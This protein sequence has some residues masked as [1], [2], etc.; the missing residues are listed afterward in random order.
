MR[1]LLLV[2]LS[3]PFA[4]RALAA[5][6]PAEQPVLLA[7]VVVSGL[8]PGPGMWRVHHGEH[9]L[10]VLATVR[11]LPRDIEWDAHEVEAVIAQAQEVLGAPTVKLRSDRGRLRSMLLLPA[12]LR[13]RRDPDGRSLEAQ[14]PP[15]DY[16]RWTVLKARYIGRDRAVE[17]RRPLLAAQALYEAAIEDVGLSQRSVVRPVVRRAARRHDVPRTEVAVELEIAN[18]KEAVRGLAAARLDDLD[19]FRST[20]ARIET[21]L[22]AMRR[23]ANAWAVGD[24]GALRTLAEEEQ[25]D[26]CL[27]AVTESAIAERLGATD[28]RGR[29]RSA[30][31]AEAERA[32]AANPVTFASMPAYELLAEDG[33]LA[34]LAARGYRVEAPG[35]AGTD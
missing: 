23:R 10:H 27:A 31:I 2:L 21:D 1:L 34:T 33:P 20:L 25:L 26:A 22:D 13:A 11:P 14:V 35:A 12:L 7:P 6:P 5:D 19:C 32:L 24:I 3:L 15:E 29:M 28:L 16:A 9:V 17:R 8:Q 30:W 18:L 4:A